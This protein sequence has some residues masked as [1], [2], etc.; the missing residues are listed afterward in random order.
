MISVTTLLIIELI[1]AAAL[2]HPLIVVNK[3]IYFNF[4]NFIVLLYCNSTKTETY[5]YVCIESVIC[6]LLRPMK[7]D[8]SICFLLF[9]CPFLLQGFHRITARAE[10]TVSVPASPPQYVE[11]TWHYVRSSTR[12]CD[13]EIE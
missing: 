9:L 6:N 7:S 1:I 8:Y 3:F 4:K 5:M 10:E 11:G 12:K 13:S 2:F